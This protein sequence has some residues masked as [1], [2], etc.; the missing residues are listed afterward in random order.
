MVEITVEAVKALRALTGAGVMECK[1]A[2]E[3]AQGDMEKAQAILR[4]RGAASAAKLAHRETRQGLVEAY[5][6]SGG[7]IGALVEVNCETDFVAR[8]EVFQAL[9]HDLAMQVAAMS[10]KYLSKEE[11][12]PAETAPPSEVCLL[13]QPFIKDP[14]R[15]VQ[16][17]IN[18]VIAKT[19]ENVRVRR[20]ARF[21]LG[22]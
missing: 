4:A 5:I 14:T 20:F 3:E 21:A 18:E 16:D 19:G 17:R 6:H 13:Q 12:P 10:P 22:E 8:T 11:M 9:A 7:R 15:T 1:K 2:L